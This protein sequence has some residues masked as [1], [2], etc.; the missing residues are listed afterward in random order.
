MRKR[1]ELINIRVD[2]TEKRKIKKNADLCGLSIS[3]YIRKAALEKEIRRIPSR[4][5]YDA[6]EFV[7]LNQDGSDVMQH[8]AKLILAAY[9]AEEDT[10]GSN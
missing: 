10:D 5:L 8:A 6:Y 1:K 4:Q 2:E 9:L 7:S 3:E